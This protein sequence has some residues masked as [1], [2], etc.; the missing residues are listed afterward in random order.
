[1]T[2]QRSFGGRHRRGETWP[3]CGHPRTKHN[4]TSSGYPQ[5]RECKREDARR[6]RRRAKEARALAAA[7]RRR[8]LPTSTYALLMAEAKAEYQAAL[9]REKEARKGGRPPKPGGGKTINVGKSLNPYR[10]QIAAQRCD[11]AD[12]LIVALGQYGGGA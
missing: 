4:T 8:V 1:M 7:E 3:S 9:E 2:R 10:P 11:P 12:A 6:A 5:C